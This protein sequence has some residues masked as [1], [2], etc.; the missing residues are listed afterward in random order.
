MSDIKW[1]N[2]VANDSLLY[3]DFIRDLRNRM[4]IEQDR[5]LGFFRSQQHSQGEIALGAMEA[6]KELIFH[7]NNAYK[8]G[9]KEDKK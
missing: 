3:S 9:R 4:S 8:E 2:A 5:A 7:V 6:Y 1:M